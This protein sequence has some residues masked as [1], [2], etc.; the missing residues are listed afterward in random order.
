MQEGHTLVQD[1]G[2]ATYT[3]QDQ[4]KVRYFANIAGMAYDA[5]LV[6]NIEAK[7]N[8]IT[9]SIIYILFL[10][11]YLL[12]YRLTKAKVSFDQQVIEQYYYT[13]NVGICRYSGGGMQIVPHAKPDDGWLAVTLAGKLSKLKVILNTFRLYNGTIGK[14]KEIDTYLTKEI[15]IE[16]PAT[17][18][19]LIEADGEFL[20]QTPVS[21]SILSKALRIIVPR[22]A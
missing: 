19:C 4:K 5:Y 10:L 13:I 8:R 21:I 22:P 18:P 12:K 16:A 6:K 9:G 1:I 3:E 17:T 20:G 2:V 11:V 7:K 14:L 15:H